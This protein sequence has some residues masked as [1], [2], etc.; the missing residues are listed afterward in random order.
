MCQ[1]GKKTFRFF[2]TLLFAAVYFWAEE[3]ANEK[4]RV[5][6]AGGTDRRDNPS[7]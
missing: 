3:M 5:C 4:R 2:F 1:A 7:D 6:N